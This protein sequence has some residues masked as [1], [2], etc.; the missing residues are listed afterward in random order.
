MILALSFL[1][2]GKANP[3]DYREF[4]RTNSLSHEHLLSAK[5][6]LQ[7]D[8][9]FGYEIENELMKWYSEFTTRVLNTNQ[10]GY[11][12][13]TRHDYLND[14]PINQSLRSGEEYLDFMK[15]KV[16]PRIVEFQGMIRHNIR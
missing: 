3:V 9:L 4:I 16:L 11:Y 10:E 14:P 8:H 15:E 7:R 5:H 12:F 13:D 2:N 1:I 6:F